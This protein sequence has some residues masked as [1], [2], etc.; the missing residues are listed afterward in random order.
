MSDNLLKERK[1]EKKKYNN[2]KVLFSLLGLMTT[3]FGFL[4][5]RLGTKNFTFRVAKRTSRQP[6]P[7]GQS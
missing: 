2:D 4:L 6:V 7:I 3:Q 1:N 5:C